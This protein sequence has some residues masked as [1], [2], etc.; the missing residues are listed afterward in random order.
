MSYPTIERFAGRTMQGLG[1]VDQDDAL[2][3]LVSVLIPYMVDSHAIAR[4]MCR[5]GIPPAS[6]RRGLATAEASLKHNAAQL[7]AMP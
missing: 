6:V 7:G 1:D 3:L 5:A 2:A 4:V